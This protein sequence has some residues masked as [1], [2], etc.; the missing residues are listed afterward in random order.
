[1]R[2]PKIHQ[3]TLRSENIHVFEEI[4]V[5]FKKLNIEKCFTQKKDVK[6]TFNKK[7]HNNFNINTKIRGKFL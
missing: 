5:D 2:N 4:E 1:M 7:S 6:N 3:K